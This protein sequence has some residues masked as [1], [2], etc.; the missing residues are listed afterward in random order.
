MI[1]MHVV[2][3]KMQSAACLQLKYKF[4]AP[5][6]FL[7]LSRYQ[8]KLLWYENREINVKIRFTRLKGCPKCYITLR[9]SETRLEELMLYKV[10]QYLVIWQMYRDW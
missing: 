10:F 1:Y 9:I 6:R 2:N 3:R 4:T 8:I 5:T 7:S